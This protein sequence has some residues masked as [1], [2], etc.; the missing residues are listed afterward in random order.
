MVMPGSSLYDFGDSIRFGAS[1]AV[2]DETD[3]SKVSLDMNLYEISSSASG[4]NTLANVIIG[5]LILM[6]LRKDI[7]NKG[8]KL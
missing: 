6:Y 2:E 5:V 8:V 3:L 7:I 1:T 4:P